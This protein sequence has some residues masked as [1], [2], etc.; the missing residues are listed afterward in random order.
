MITL[1]GVTIHSKIYES[2]ATLVYRGIREQENCGAIAKVLKQDYPSSGE[3]TRYRQE[4]A[5]AGYSFGRL[6]WRVFRILDAAAIRLLSHA[7]VIFFGCRDR[8]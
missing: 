1:P 4:P 6:W 3:L 2:L 8:P 7:F 5:H